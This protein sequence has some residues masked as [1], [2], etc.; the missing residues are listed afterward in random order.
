MSLN[1]KNPEA[2]RLAAEIG[3]LTGESKTAAVVSAL[4][5]RHERLLAKLQQTEDAAMAEDILALAAKIRSRVGELELSS[6]F[7]YDPET[8]LPS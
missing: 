2:E 1:I 6:D 8:G 4:R 5:E 3:A 7:L